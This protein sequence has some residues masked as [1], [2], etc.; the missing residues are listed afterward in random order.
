MLLLG[1]AAGAAAQPARIEPKPKGTFVLDEFA[2][3]HHWTAARQSADW[4]QRERGVAVGIGD[5]AAAVDL[6]A[7]AD[8][9]AEPKRLLLSVDTMVE[10]VHFKPAT[11]RD[12]DVGFKALAASVS[13]I[14]A[15]GGVPLHALVSVS[16]PPAYGPER[17]RRLYDGLYACA[18]RYGV[19]VAGGDTTS[20]PAQLVVAVTVTGTVEAGRELRRSGA[21]PGDAVF[22]TGAVGLSAAGLHALL[23]LEAAGGGTD[24]TEDDACE[25]IAKASGLPPGKAKPLVREHRR[26]APSVR[27]GRL[28]LERGT[29]RS[30]NDVSDGLASEAWE[31][32]EASGLK[33]T[34]EERLLPRSGSLAAYAA[35]AGIDPLEWMLYGGEDYCLIGTVA[36]EDAEA[37][38]EAFHAE[39]LPFF[40][41]GTAEEGTPG[42]ELLRHDGKRAALA[43]RGYNHFD[44]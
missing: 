23:A 38:R 34:L 16:V 39:G 6:A 15:M 37:L 11:M 8:G 10:T 32:A 44:K 29:C 1:T 28:L 13:D 30:L 22:V 4:Q 18:E 25:A 42:V 33:L 9:V 40:L 31:I 14:A 27:A 35:S 41:I 26:P 2:R 36:A 7:A 19:A 3:I 21:K 24:M 43:K 5:D 12:E 17:M 20:S